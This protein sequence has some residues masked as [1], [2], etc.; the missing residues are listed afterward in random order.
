MPNF[1][2]LFGQ[3]GQS[4]SRG[5]SSSWQ[6]GDRVLAPWEPSFLYAGTRD[7]YAR[8][9]LAAEPFSSVSFYAPP[10]PGDL[11]GRPNVTGR[12][13]GVSA[14]WWTIAEF[15]SQVL[16]QRNVG[17]IVR[18]MALQAI[19]NADDACQIACR[20]QRDGDTSKPGHSLRPRTDVKLFVD[21]PHVGVDR[22][23]ANAEVV[24][25]LFGTM[26][27]GQEPQDFF[28]TRR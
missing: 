25:D 1:D 16:C 12:T 9:G 17:C 5:S 21:L 26:A 11:T 23:R 4:A 8:L 14:F 20:K 2:D 3:S 18:T 24:G 28:F 10:T 7:E 13:S 19:G 22:P 6:V 27:L 15:C